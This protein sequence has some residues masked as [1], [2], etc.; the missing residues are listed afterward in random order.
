MKTNYD[1]IRNIFIQ[2][3]LSSA[4][5]EQKIKALNF[6]AMYIGELNYWFWRY[7]FMKDITKRAMSIK[8]MKYGLDN[9]TVVETID[10]LNST[11]KVVKEML[12]DAKEKVK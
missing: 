12:E 10:A 11:R 9:L 6:G 4:L 3:S 5:M 7:V 2:S 8:L 1:W